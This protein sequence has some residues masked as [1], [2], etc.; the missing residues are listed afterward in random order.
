MIK[1]VE[2]KNTEIRTVKDMNVRERV[3]SDL[4]GTLNEDRARTMKSLLIC[5]QEIK[6]SKRSE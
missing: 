1:E 6:A 2:S 3:M 4:L 5:L